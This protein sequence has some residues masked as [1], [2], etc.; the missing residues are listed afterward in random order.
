LAWAAVLLGSLLTMIGFAKMG[1]DL[2]WKSD[3]TAQTPLWPI[4]ILLAAIIG[5]TVFAAPVMDYL[6][7]PSMFDLPAYIAVQNLGGM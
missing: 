2:Y 7:D 6:S 5:L 1:S 3:D 4:G